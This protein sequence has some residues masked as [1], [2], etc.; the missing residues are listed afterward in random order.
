M[1]VGHVEDSPR[2]ANVLWD[3]H[4]DRLDLCTSSV[5]PVVRGN[6]ADPRQVVVERYLVAAHVGTRTTPGP[7]VT[8]EPG[9]RSM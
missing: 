9:K 8:F 2:S 5:Q 4:V 1:Y 6:A 3:V 7:R